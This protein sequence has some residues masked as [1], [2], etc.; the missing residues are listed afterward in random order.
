MSFGHAVIDSCT[1]SEI[2]RSSGALEYFVA[3]SYCHSLELKITAYYF[4][5]LGTLGL[6]RILNLLSK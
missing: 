1:K 2:W 4:M 5:K 6:V 3:S